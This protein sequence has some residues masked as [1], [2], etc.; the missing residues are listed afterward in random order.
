MLLSDDK[1]GKILNTAIIQRRSESNVNS[2]I[3]CNYIG[4]GDTKLDEL[5]EDYLEQVFKH[6]DDI[7]LC[8]IHYTS[9]KFCAM[10]TLS[11]KNR[12]SSQNAGNSTRER[13]ILFNFVVDLFAI[14]LIVNRC[15]RV[16]DLSLYLK[17]LLIISV[18]K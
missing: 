10:A 13:L 12:F 4:Y 5:S 18:H 8:A 15:K 9:S 7:D 2:V 17:K 1:I 16:K 6:L 14:L 11:F 3:E